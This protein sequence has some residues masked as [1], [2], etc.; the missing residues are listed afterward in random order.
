MVAYTVF[1]QV[2]N[3]LSPGYLVKARQPSA[4]PF[5]PTVDPSTGWIDTGRLFRWPG[6]GAN[7]L[8]AAKKP[9]AAG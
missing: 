3:L 2:E 7:T 9:A 4:L 1:P 6:N 8:R 5:H